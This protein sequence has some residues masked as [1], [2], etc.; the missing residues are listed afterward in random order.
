MGDL[1]RRIRDEIERHRA[2]LALLVALFIIIF[3]TLTP[4]RFHFFPLSLNNY[5]VEFSYGKRDPF[6]FIRNILL[7]M[8]LG[9]TLGA[10]L[11]RRGWSKNRVFIAAFFS[12]L[13]LTLTV[14][15]LQQFLPVRQAS[16]YDL[17]SNT[18]GSVVGLGSYW[19]WQDRHTQ[20]ERVR[21]A[22]NEPPKVLAALAIYMLL[23]LLMA[24]SLAASVRITSWDKRYHLML[25]NEWTADR[26]WI[27]SLR[28][29]EIINEALDIETARQI[30]N[31]PDI[32]LTNRESLQAYYPLTGDEPYQDLTGKL[33]DLIRQEEG[34]S[35]S[36]VEAAY[37]NGRSWLAT[38]IPVSD[39]IRKLEQTSQFSIRLTANTADIEQSGPARIL[40]LSEDPFFRNLT[41][42]Q[43]QD[44]L[45]MRVRTPLMGDNGLKPEFFFPDFFT[46]SGPTDFVLIY[47]GMAVELIDSQSQTV[48]SIEVVPGVVFYTWLRELVNTNEELTSR[49]TFGG[50]NNWFY[51]LLF[52]T[53]VFVPV[54]ILLALTSQRA[55]SKYTKILI[56]FSCLLLVP[57]LFEL[58]LVAG[59]GFQLR[60]LNVLTGMVVIAVTGWLIVRLSIDCLAP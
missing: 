45:V 9:F 14:E 20:I 51:R 49:V 29:L 33:P 18:L 35:G 8:P 48:Q 31:S 37:F 7:F 22:S 58:F 55:W 57:L 26:P 4:F 3:A 47:N 50:I 59:G 5:L 54:G 52:Y 13:L 38:E 41:I 19:F 11:D 15:S 1:I 32:T 25:G 40:S 30:M 21:L 28:D 2:P 16:I 36:E 46:S 43:E 44:G 56:G 6:D 27:G 24:T 10:I 39:L 60:P 34:E 53:V 23:L 12:G 42:G 17:I